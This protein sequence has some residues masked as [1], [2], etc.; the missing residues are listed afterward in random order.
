M[1]GNPLPAGLK[2]EVPEMGER[3]KE[4]YKFQNGVM[5]NLRDTYLSPN[6]S[7]YCWTLF[8]ETCGYGDYKVKI[9]RSRI[10]DLTR[11]LEVNVSR[12]ERRLKERNIII[13]NSKYKG[14]N[15]DIAKWEKVSLLIPFE[16][17][18]LPI[19]K[20]IARAEKKGIATD[21]LLTKKKENSKKG[22]V[23]LK[24]LSY[25]EAEKF[26]GKKWLKQVMWQRGNF[27]EN[28]ID[29]IFKIYSFMQCYDTYIAYGEAHNVRDKEAWFLAKLR[30]GPEQEE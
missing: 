21:T 7:K 28:F 25:K 6:E 24:K 22:G 17:V 12:T 1:G 29:K 26:E 27:T 18:S 3:T 13:V 23:G 14:F 20:G 5:E 4:F 8:R 11:I 30:Q 10:S 16:K 19:Q 2:E 15:P 9:S